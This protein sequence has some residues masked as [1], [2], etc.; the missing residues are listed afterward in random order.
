VLWWM[1]SMILSIFHIHDVSGVSSTSCP[2]TN[3]IIDIF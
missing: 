3:V 2:Q 1:L